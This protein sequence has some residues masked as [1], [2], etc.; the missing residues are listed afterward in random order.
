MAT[1]KMGEKGKIVVDLFEAFS[2]IFIKIL[3]WFM[4]STPVGV[5]SLIAV[6]VAQ[7][8]DIEDTFNSLGLLVV[9]FLIGILLQQLVLY[10]SALFIIFRM[11]PLYFYFKAAKAWMA[12]FGPPS[13]AMGIPE[14]LRL[15][16]EDFHVD[17]RVSRFTVPFGAAECRIGSMHF[18]ALS[19]L[20]IAA[21]QGVSLSPLQVAIVWILCSLS[22]LAVPAVPSSS[23]VVVLIL[24]TSVDVDGEAMGILF[25]LEWFTDRLRSTSNAMA[26]TIC[27]MLVDKLCRGKLEVVTSGK[28]TSTGE[29]GADTDGDF[30]DLADDSKDGPNSVLLKIH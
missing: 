2:L 17:K 26:S 7:V 23:L 25:T 11:N 20:F 18:I 24:L 3:T 9:A 22:S 5:A 12:V 13:S 8:N 15:C 1:S 30:S 21:V 29:G 27:T 16:E 10:P 28:T 6:S 4:W 14:I 19:A